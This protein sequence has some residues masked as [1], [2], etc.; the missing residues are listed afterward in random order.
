MHQ[1]DTICQI[2]CVL[3]HFFTKKKKKL[4]CYYMTVCKICIQTF[5]SETF[6]RRTGMEFLKKNYKTSNFATLLII[7]FLSTN[8]RGLLYILFLR[9]SMWEN[10]FTVSFPFLQ[11]FL[12]LLW[13]L[14][15]GELNINRS[16]RWALHPSFVMK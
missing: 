15:V 10:I 1:C 13:Y 7:N 3:G 12:F 2:F 4:F 14:L 6:D 16:V 5:L 8:F 11:C 9:F